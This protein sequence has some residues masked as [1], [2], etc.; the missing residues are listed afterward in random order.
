KAT[1]RGLGQPLEDIS[2]SFDPLRVVF[3][4]RALGDSRPWHFEQRLIG[5]GH[6]LALA[7]RQAGEDASV[8]FREMQLDSLLA[9]ADIRL[10]AAAGAISK[11]ESAPVR[12]P[13]N[14]ESRDGPTNAAE[15]Q[16]RGRR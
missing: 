15:D 13:E 6:M 16:I 4:D 2:F 11:N 10:S 5:G 3:H 8:S 12:P 14:T 9:E 7:W 1:G